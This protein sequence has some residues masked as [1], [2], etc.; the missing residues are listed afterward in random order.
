[1]LEINK[2]HQGDC[3]ELI[4]N[5]PDDSINLVVIDPPYNIGI[6]EWDDIE[7]YYEWMKEVFIEI[8]RVLKNSGSLYFFHNNFLKM[9]ELQNK[10][11][12]N[13]R[14]NFKQMLIWDKFNGTKAGDCGRVSKGINNYPKQAE[15]ILY[16]TMLKGN[17][18]FGNENIRDYFNCE[19]NKIKE[20]LISINRKAFGATDGKDGMAGNILSPY[21]KG[22]SFPSKDKYTKLQETYGICN[23]PYDELKK[24]L[25]GKSKITIFNCQ[26]NAS[27]M[28]FPH[29]SPNGHITPKPIELLKNLIKTS[30]EEGDLILDCF[31]GSGSTALACQQI[32]RKFIG[33]EK[34]SKYVEIAN[35]RLSQ[36]SLFE[37]HKPEVDRCSPLDDK[38]EGGNGIPPTNELV[39]ILPKI[40]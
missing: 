7:N 29:E 16:Y 10:I 8:E 5:I 35:K 1:M 15:Y 22:W 37:L 19:R 38:Q 12:R 27:V 21:K 13:T 17:E 6:D 23:T 32:N 9:V 34:E 11:N 30:S 25:K 26:G 24:D 3:L 31:M 2:I 18:P 33:I 40:I 14:L 28:Q 20:S 39:G 36:K 4:K